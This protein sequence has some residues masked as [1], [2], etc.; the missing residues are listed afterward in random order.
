MMSLNTP[1]NHTEGINEKTP[2]NTIQPTKNIKWTPDNE[3]ILVE[4]CDIANCYKWL[5]TRCHYK[6]S[7]L[8]AW[9]TIP[10]IVFST[11]S[12]TASFAQTSLPSSMQI[13]SPM[14][15]G[16][17]N[18]LIGIFTTIQQYLKIS[19]RNELHRV[20]GL[21]W[22][23][24]ARNISIELTKDPDERIDAGHFIKNCR[25]EFDRLMETSPSID[26][27]TV[28]EFNR[29]FKG[30]VSKEQQEKFAKKQQQRFQELRKPDICDVIVPCNEKR[31]NWYKD[32]INIANLQLNRE[33]TLA[34]IANRREEDSP[35]LYDRMSDYA[36][37]G[38]VSSTLQH[39][40]QYGRDRGRSRIRG[41]SS[42]SVIKDDI[43]SRYSGLDLMNDVVEKNHSNTALDAGEKVDET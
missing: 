29:T 7:I 43:E 31:H 13:Y 17:I 30:V 9:F 16:S 21:L 20:S 32:P 28:D 5:H 19:E 40:A 38:S 6:L 37:H 39:D 2:T 24:L 8:H 33:E 22:D 18:I 27:K 12:G 11:I 14:V 15:I 10:T 1:S 23:K 41:R 26:Q 25:Q 3:L 34:S 35:N 36:R 4:W 42:L